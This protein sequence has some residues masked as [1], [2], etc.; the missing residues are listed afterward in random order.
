M[1]K[2]KRLLRVLAKLALFAAVLD[3]NLMCTFIF[4]QKKMPEQL[5][6]LRK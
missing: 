6:D 5:R 1:M 3:A 2:N 4:G